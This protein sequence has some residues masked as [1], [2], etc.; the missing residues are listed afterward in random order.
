MGIPLVARVACVFGAGAFSLVAW[1]G[2]EAVLNAG[3][4]SERPV[5]GG[6]PQGGG[7]QGGGP[8]GGGGQDDASAQDETGST[9]GAF[10]PVEGGARGDEARQT[11]SE[12]G[13]AEVDETGTTDA[14]Q[15]YEDAA[16]GDATAEGSAPTGSEASPLDETA[17][18]GADAGQ[19]DGAMGYDAGPPPADAAP[20]KGCAAGAKMLSLKL[21]TSAPFGTLG[22]VCVTYAGTVAGW[23]ASNAKGRSVTAVGSKTVTLTTIPEGTNQQ[24]LG[25]GAD[26]FIYWNF[27]AG[28]YTYAAMYAYP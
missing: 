24:A 1:T 5:E 18:A 21:S 12:A 19:P 25:P 7:P 11:L 4:I 8:Q 3:A 26:G 2:C 16:G 6:G 13:P 17:E 15:P 23:N 22:A 14:T 20:P 10:N 28:T 9:E 27:S